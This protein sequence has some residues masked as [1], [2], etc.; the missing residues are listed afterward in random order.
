MPSPEFESVLGM[1]RAQPA[2]GNQ[3][4]EQMR[5]GL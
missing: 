5:A 2:L 1:M 3:S 4:V